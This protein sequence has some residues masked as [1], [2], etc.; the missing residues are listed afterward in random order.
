MGSCAASTLEAVYSGPHECATRRSEQVNARDRAFEV[1]GCGARAAAAAASFKLPAGQEP[2]ATSPDWAHRCRVQLGRLVPQECD[3]LILHVAGLPRPRTS[4]GWPM[5]FAGNDPSDPCATD[6]ELE[7]MC[8]RERRC[9]VCGVEI[10]SIAYAIRRPGHQFL[11]RS[12][13]AVPWVEGRASL[14]LACLR[15]TLRYCPEMIRQV[16]QG[17]AHV[18]R[19]PKKGCQNVLDGAMLDTREYVA[20]IEP[21]WNLESAMDSGQAV[22]DELRQLERAA[23]TNATATAALFPQLARRGCR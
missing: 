8:S 20:F 3:R 2:S 22:N 19:E 11:S 10:T 6:R 17:V 14:H 4:E 1:R 21:V 13:Q 9:Q 15:S 16:R 23:R 12:G 5:P 18:T 7:C